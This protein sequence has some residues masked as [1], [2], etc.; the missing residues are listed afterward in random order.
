MIHFNSFHLIKA[1]INFS[2]Q[3]AA[4]LERDDEEVQPSI[5]VKVYLAFN[6]IVFFLSCLSGYIFNNSQDS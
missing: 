5:T 6:K 1:E 2:I 3:Q 4:D